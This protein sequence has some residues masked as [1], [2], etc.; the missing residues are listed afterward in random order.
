MGANFIEIPVKYAE[1]RIK[2]TGRL[3]TRLTP[4][5]IGPYTEATVYADMEPYLSFSMFS[6]LFKKQ[7]TK[8]GHLMTLS[9]WAPIADAIKKGYV[10]LYLVTPGCFDDI[11]LTANSIQYNPI[12]D[13]FEFRG[14]FAKEEEK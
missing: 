12:I 2:D 3:F 13:M 4:E 6:I 9:D 14:A 1:L 11:K 5:F 8:Y 7:Q 10:V